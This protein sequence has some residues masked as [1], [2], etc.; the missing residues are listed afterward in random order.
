MVKWSSVCCVN[1]LAIACCVIAWHES[2]MCIA[3]Y[4]LYSLRHLCDDHAEHLSNM[5]Y[6]IGKFVSARL[7]RRIEQKNRRDHKKQQPSHNRAVRTLA[8]QIV[9]I[10]RPSD[11]RGRRSTDAP[12]R[13][14]VARPVR[15]AAKNCSRGATCIYCVQHKRICQG[16]GAAGTGQK[17]R[18]Q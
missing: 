10:S 14:T 6:R 15:P 3:F 4:S 9:A 18:Y 7:R 12:L 8:I 1:H 16:G 2:L 17:R 11:S 13:S 5:S